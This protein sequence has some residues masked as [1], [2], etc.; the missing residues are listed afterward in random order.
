MSMPPVD[1]HRVD[2]DDLDVARVARRA[3]CA[4]SLLPDAVGP[5]MTDAATSARSVTGE[6]GDAPL[7]QWLGE[8]LDELADEVVRRGAR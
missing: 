4:T 1:L 2:G 3:P 8:Q 5:R 6:H 7:V